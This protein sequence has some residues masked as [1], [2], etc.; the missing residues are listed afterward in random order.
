MATHKKI[1][2]SINYFHRI[3]HRGKITEED[4]YVNSHCTW[5][6]KQS[7]AEVGIVNNNR[8]RFLL[9]YEILL[10]YGGPFHKALGKP[11]NTNPADKLSPG[12]YSLPVNVGENLSL[13]LNGIRD[14]QGYS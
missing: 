9:T 13:Y 6:D 11:D 5:R 12:L 10:L 1:W 7:V 2:E 8:K 14:S 4:I 3:Q